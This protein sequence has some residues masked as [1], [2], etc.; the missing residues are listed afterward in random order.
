ML[1]ASVDETGDPGT[2]GQGRP[3]FCWA[4]FVTPYESLRPLGSVR[5]WLASRLP[6]QS[7]R[8]EHWACDGDNLLAV[9]R[10]LARLPMWNWLAVI[11]KTTMAT[12]STAAYIHDPTEHRYFTLLWLLERLS[13][14]GE[15]KGEPVLAFVERTNARTFNQGDLRAR[16]QRGLPKGRGANHDYLPPGNVLLTDAQHV[17]LLNFA[18]TIA[19]TVGKAVNPH[20]AWGNT[21]PE[22]LRVVLDRVWIGPVWRNRSLNAYGFCLLPWSRYDELVQELP[23]LHDWLAQLGLRR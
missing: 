6:G 3:W 11:S 17:P 9:L 22:Y 12:A 18:H 19:F 20:M 7:G 8:P 2:G 23:F 10:I 4:A 5:D 14:M 13:W 21:F 1:I 16:Y 15:S